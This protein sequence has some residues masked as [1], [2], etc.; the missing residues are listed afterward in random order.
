MLLRRGVGFREVFN[1]G[2]QII[3]AVQ[4]RFQQKAKTKMAVTATRMHQNNGYA[5]TCMLIARIFPCPFRAKYYATRNYLKPFH[6]FLVAVLCKIAIKSDMTM[7]TFCAAPDNEVFI[8][9]INFNSL[10]LTYKYNKSYLQ[11]THL[12]SLAN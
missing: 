10:P 6:W 8:P 5:C 1:N 12:S 2:S 4:P 7:S 11:A 3:K 9:F